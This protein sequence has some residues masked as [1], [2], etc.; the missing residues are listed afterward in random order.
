MKRSHLFLLAAVGVMA[1]F[2]ALSTAAA[3]QERNLILTE[4]SAEVMGQ[5]DSAAISFSVMT[6]GRDLE[7]VST[8]NAAGTEAVLK[9][10]KDLKIANLR[11]QTSNFRVEP[12]TDY[13]ARPPRITGYRVY[14]AIELTLETLAPEDLSRHV[15]KIIGVALQN[16][17][18]SVQR[19]DFYIKNKAPLEKEA[20]TLAT[21]EALDRA[22]VLAQAAGVTLKRIASISTQPMQPAP[23]RPMMRAA[24]TAD[25]A[26]PPM[27]SGESVVRAQVQI[28][29]EIE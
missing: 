24:M 4:G 11:V 20:L 12:L 3:A 28:A 7:A 18:N 10:I 15:S 2:S 9:S 29:Y 25:A 1:V 5:N 6:E 14:N 26:A 8:D 27:E 23:I 21:R 22:A 13:K 19:L 17:A 16:G